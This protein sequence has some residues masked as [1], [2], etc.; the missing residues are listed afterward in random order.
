MA[1]RSLANTH[2]K[3]HATEGDNVNEKSRERAVALGGGERGES[4]GGEK[5]RVMVA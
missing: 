5:E 2:E 4:G 1:I 3:R